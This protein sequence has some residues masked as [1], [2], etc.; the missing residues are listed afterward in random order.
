M[1]FARQIQGD[2]GFQ[3]VPIFIRKKSG[4]GEPTIRLNPVEPLL[5]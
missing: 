1:S 4:F 5:V 3:N 2:V